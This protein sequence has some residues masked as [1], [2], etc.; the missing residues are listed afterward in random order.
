MD[1]SW[2]EASSPNIDTYRNGVVVATV[3][4]NGF[5]TD[6]L[7]GRGHATYIYTVCEAGTG[8]RSNQVTVTF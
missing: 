6:H 3:P 4:N 2:S 1:L 8:N 7:N 5:Y